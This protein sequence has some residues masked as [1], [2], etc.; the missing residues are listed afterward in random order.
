VQLVSKFIRERRGNLLQTFIGLII[1]GALSFAFWNNW[2]IN[3][4]NAGTSLKVKIES[5]SWLAE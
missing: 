1:M 5:D 3:M 4:T 2:E